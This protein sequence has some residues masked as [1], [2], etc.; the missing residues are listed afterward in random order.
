MIKMSD[1]LSAKLSTFTNAADKENIGIVVI[2]TN[3]EQVECMASPAYNGF[4]ILGILG[5]AFDRYV[6]FGLRQAVCALD[7]AKMKAM[8]EA[9]KVSE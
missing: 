6:K 4:H 1:E 2:M 3:G 5:N 8:P 9:E 7:M